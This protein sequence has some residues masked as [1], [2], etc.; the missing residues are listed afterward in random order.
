VTPVGSDG[1]TYNVAVSGMTKSGTVLASIAA[2]TAQDAHG[3]GNDASTSTDN[4]VTFDIT[5]RR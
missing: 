3:V 2:G 4:S 1:T 5:P